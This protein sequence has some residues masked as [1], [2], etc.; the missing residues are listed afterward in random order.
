MGSKV[1]RGILSIL[2]VVLVV[3]LGFIGLLILDGVTDTGGVEAANIIVA[4]GSGGDYS[5]IQA[6]IN[7]ANNGD[8]IYIW[9]GTYYENVVVNKTV[10]IIGNGTGKTFINGSRTGDTIIVKSDGVNITGVKVYIRIQTVI[11]KIIVF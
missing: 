2:T 1:K 8:T 3:N 5:T 6:A 11:D 7:N 10:T 4:K 9:S